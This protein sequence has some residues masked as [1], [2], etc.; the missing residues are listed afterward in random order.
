[1]A[2]AVELR[3]VRHDAFIN[4]LDQG[5]LGSCT[6]NAGVAAVYRDPFV[7]G[8]VKPWEYGPS[9][10]GAVSL[11]SAATHADPYQGDYPPDDTGSDGL[12]VAK[13]LKAQ[14]II[15]GYLWAFT[16]DE[17]LGQLMTLPLVTGIVWLQSMF[18]V[19][20]SGLIHVDRGSAVA[21]GHELCVDE[22]KPADGPHPA[23]V[24]GPNSWGPSWGDGGRWY[25]TVD[26]WGWLLAQQG[27]VTAFL[28][29][30]VPPPDP[31]PTPGGLTA[32]DTLW[33]ETRAWAAARHTGSN[34]RAAE[35]V[36][37]WAKTTGRS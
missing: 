1:M 30:N 12:S 6:G 32:E 27:D 14:G 20:G 19:D 26:D 8:V 7:R 29:G 22:Y 23:V 5:Q 11:Y 4:I 3:P 28:P 33:F 18:D 36:R 15:S 9:E 37:R 10:A 31:A 17:A 2:T 21:G 16:L 25:L 13:V 35:S 24:G 34:A